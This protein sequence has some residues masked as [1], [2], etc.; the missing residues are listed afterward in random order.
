MTVDWHSRFTQQS[1]WT[2]ELREYIFRRA[3]LADAR[4]ILEV[5]CGTGAVLSGLAGRRMAVHGLDLDAGRLAEC[6]VHAPGTRLT[7]GDALSLPYPAE[8]FDICF[9][10]FLL[11]W[12]KDPLQT[13]LEMKRVTRPGGHVLALAE[14]DY[15]QRVDKPDSLAVLGVW[16]AQSLRRQGADPGLGSRLA[17]LF[18]RAG[19]GILE[20]GTLGAG[21]M[22][23]LTSEEQEM[24]WAV[25]EAD[26]K[27]FVPVRE[28][29]RLKGLDREAWQR[30]ERVLHVPT[31]FA[32]GATLFTK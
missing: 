12:V 9:C 13:L 7:C 24:E 2:R 10:H 17:D 27:D 11:L 3:G 4:H 1:E 29:Q 26:L 22:S 32:Y 23:L 6:K 25:L 16:Q 18:S 14:P 15:N 19:I 5:G 30:G 21:E 8:T 28:I 20:T 31:Y